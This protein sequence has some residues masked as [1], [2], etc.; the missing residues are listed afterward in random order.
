MQSRIDR[1][2]LVVGLG[3]PGPV[4]EGTRHNVGYEVVNSFA[5]KH[6]LKWRQYPLALIAD[7]DIAECRIFL[8]KPLTF[9]NLSGLAVLWAV[10]RYGIKPEDLILVS[11]D[12]D[13][14]LGT[15][16]IR[17]GGSDGGHRGVRSVVESLKTTA[18][19]RIRIGIGKPPSGVDAA[20]YV[21]SPFDAEELKDIT[22]IIHT[23]VE[24]L[25]IAVVSG[26]RVA[27]NKYN[28]RASSS[29]E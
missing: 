20:D 12:M 21:L 26:L 2:R 1:I 8:L 22:G 18:I 19:P 7:G 6:G 16:R 10:Q 23:A 15:I 29:P 17:E 5:T 13:L 4:Y 24:A 9:M 14:P 27:M 25:E 3:N 11:D 28:I